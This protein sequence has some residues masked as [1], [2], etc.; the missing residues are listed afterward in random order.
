[1]VRNS[2]ASQSISTYGTYCVRNLVTN[3]ARHEHWTDPIRSDPDPDPIRFGDVMSKSDPVEIRSGF[4][5]RIRNKVAYSRLEESS[6]GY[7]KKIPKEKIGGRIGS[8]LETGSG[9]SDSM[10]RSQSDS[11]AK[12]VKP[13]RNRRIGFV[14]AVWSKPDR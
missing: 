7:K 5:P 3:S 14:A 12:S 6:N 1:M 8:G 9:K 13:D 10:I 2:R 11:L 4:D